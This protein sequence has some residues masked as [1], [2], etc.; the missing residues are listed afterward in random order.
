[1]RTQRTL[2]Q[3]D[4]YDYQM[5]VLGSIISMGIRT[6]STIQMFAHRA[7]TARFIAGYASRN[8][9]AIIQKRDI[10][11]LDLV[12][13]CDSASS[14]D[15]KDTFIATSTIRHQQRSGDIRT[16]RCKKELD[17]NTLSASHRRDSQSHT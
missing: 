14:T 12:S 13:V 4:M 8:I 3:P 9:V 10:F 5:F 11:Y 17:G 2:W 16:G 6:S 1:M 7:W 15:K